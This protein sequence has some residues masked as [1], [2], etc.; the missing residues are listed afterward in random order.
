VN[1]QQGYK[2]CVCVFVSDHHEQMSV[3]DATSEINISLCFDVQKNAEH[4]SDWFL[5]SKKQEK[6][7]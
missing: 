7:F 3:R 5:K 4:A 2:M 1:W 6:M